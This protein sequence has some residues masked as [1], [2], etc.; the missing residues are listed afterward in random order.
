MAVA[1][2]ITRGPLPSTFEALCNLH[3]PRP[4][5]DDVDF[6]NAQE[7]VNRLAVRRPEALTPGQAEYLETLTVLMENYESASS[8]ITTGRLNPIKTLK[9]LMAGRGMN[10][11]DLGRLLGNRALGSAIL[12]GSRKLSTANI[13]AI[14]K[15]F[16]V[17]AGLF[18]K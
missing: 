9:Y 17:G 14:C 12:R 6:A 16:Q 1:N 5:R 3:W 4:I 10:A 8:P 18:L 13:R 2:K 11:S 7:I 15:H